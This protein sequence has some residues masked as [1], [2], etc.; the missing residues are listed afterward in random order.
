[1]VP[2]GRHRRRRRRRRRRPFHAPAAAPAAVAA[3][4]VAFS[5]PS[6]RY[7]ARA[8]EQQGGCRTRAGRSRPVLECACCTLTC[9]KPLLFSAQ[10]MTRTGIPSAKH[11][12]AGPARAPDPA[13]GA[14][15]RGL[16]RTVREP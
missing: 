10:S 12:P 8:G 16:D 3:A 1:M 7:P 6:K 2:P 5:A 14:G 4:T 13:R 15:R 9:R 11:R